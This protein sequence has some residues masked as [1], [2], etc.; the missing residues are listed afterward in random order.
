MAAWK[1]S[2]KWRAYQTYKRPMPP[3]RI[4]R[5]DEEALVSISSS[6]HTAAALCRC[7]ECSPFMPPCNQS[8]IHCMSNIC[9]LYVYCCGRTSMLPCAQFAHPAADI[10]MS[11]ATIVAAVACHPADPRINARPSCPDDQALAKSPAIPQVFCYQ[12]PPRPHLHPGG[13]RDRQ[14]QQWQPPDSEVDPSSPHQHHLG[15]QA[16]LRVKVHRG[17]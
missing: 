6:M 15:G 11:A 8:S 12:G 13:N 17:Q 2:G 10:A 9:A 3:S 16:S 5:D 14:A 1:T 4:N 7:V